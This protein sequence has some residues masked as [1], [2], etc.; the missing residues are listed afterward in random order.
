MLVLVPVP[1]SRLFIAMYV[2]HSA[3]SVVT[4]MARVDVNQAHVKWLDTGKV[5]L[6]IRLESTT[7]CDAVLRQARMVV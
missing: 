7:T 3:N 6:S 2:E 4:A 1:K 5:V